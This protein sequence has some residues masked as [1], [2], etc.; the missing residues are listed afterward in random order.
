[1]TEPLKHYSSLGEMVDDLKIAG[2]DADFSLREST[3][4][5][6][7]D[8]FPGVDETISTTLG[9]DLWEASGPKLSPDDDLGDEVIKVCPVDPDECESCQ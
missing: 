8:Q 5:F 4:H 7:I 9:S 6:Q 3:E 1:M 2:V